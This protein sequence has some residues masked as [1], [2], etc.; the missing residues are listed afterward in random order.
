MAVITPDGYS[1]S[2]LDEGYTEQI[3]TFEISDIFEVGN[4]LSGYTSPTSDSL[5]EP[6]YG[7]QEVTTPLLLIWQ[8][9]LF[10]EKYCTGGGGG[11]PARPTTGQ[12]YPRGYS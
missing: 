5:I 3:R 7:S 9:P 6:G 10:F 11:G 2:V 4:H 8:N 1:Y 12:V